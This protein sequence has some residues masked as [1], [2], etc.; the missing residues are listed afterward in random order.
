VHNAGSILSYMYSRA[1]PMSRTTI[2]RSIIVIVV[3]TA[4]HIGTT[5]SKRISTTT[6]IIRPTAEKTPPSLLLQVVVNVVV[7]VV[8]NFQIRYHRRGI[9]QVP[10]TAPNNRASAAAFE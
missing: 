10:L 2:T 1:I 7:V 6:A 3:V 8:V 9:F 4:Q 5:R